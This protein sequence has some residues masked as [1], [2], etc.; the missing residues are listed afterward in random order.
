VGKLGI[1]DV[2]QWIEAADVD[3]VNNSK[4]GSKDDFWYRRNCAILSKTKIRKDKTG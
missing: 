4:S 3:K 1:K 2:E